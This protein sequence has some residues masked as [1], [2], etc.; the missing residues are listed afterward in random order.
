VS[1]HQFAVESGETETFKGGRNV[2]LK[3]YAVCQLLEVVPMETKQSETRS[4]EVKVQRF[5]RPDDI[6]PEKAYCSDIREVKA[7]LKT[8]VYLCFI[9]FVDSV[10]TL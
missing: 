10:I 8:S 9:I 2:G 5:F 3:P 7:F 1:P 6:S 4:T